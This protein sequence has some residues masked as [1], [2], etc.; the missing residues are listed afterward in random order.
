[1]SDDICQLRLDF[2]TLDGF[3]TSTT[4]GACIDSFKAEGQTGRNPPTICGTN[5]GYH[6]YVEFGATNTDT[7]KLT[8]TY[9]ATTS[10]LKWNILARQISCTASW[11]APTDCTQYFTGTSGEIYSYNFAGAL[12]LQ[13]QY[14]TNCLRTEKGYCS[15]QYREKSGTTPDA[16][17]INPQ[18]SI[19]AQV[20]CDEAQL[21]IPTH[22]LDG[23]NGLGAPTIALLEFQTTL[24]GMTFGYYLSDPATYG[25][26][27]LAT[28]QKPFVVGVFSGTATQ[29]TAQTGFALEYNHVSC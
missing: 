6:M 22:S 15:V 12:F 26:L 18:P 11:K 28:S 3:A 21:F 8:T 4:V 5:T 20:V 10:S 2:E 23:F 1:M 29:T 14:Y 27:P 16:F 9:G 13:A 17:N 24:C 7:I 19:G 25:P